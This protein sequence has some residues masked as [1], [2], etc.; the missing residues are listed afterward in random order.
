[1]Q[2]TVVYIE[3]EAKNGAL[4]FMNPCKISADWNSKKDLFLF[5][6]VEWIVHIQEVLPFVAVVA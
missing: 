1:M 5:F 6:L 4:D 3:C 2:N